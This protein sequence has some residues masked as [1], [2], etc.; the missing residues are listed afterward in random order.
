MTKRI[1]SINKTIVVFK[2]N[3]INFDAFLNACLSSAYCDAK[4][5]YVFLG[6][7]DE[8]SPDN[9]NRIL[10]TLSAYRKKLYTEYAKRQ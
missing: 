7:Y 2:K 4:I 3:K 6:N 9:K 10:A 5:E 1:Y 8:M